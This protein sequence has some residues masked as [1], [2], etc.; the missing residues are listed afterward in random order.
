MRCM[1][2]EF[3]E[4]P[5]SGF[6]CTVSVCTVYQY[7][8][9]Q[10]PWS[11]TQKTRVFSTLYTMY[12]VHTVQQSQFFCIFCCLLS[13]RQESQFPNKFVYFFYFKES[14]AVIYISM[15]EF[16]VFHF[17]VYCSLPLQLLDPKALTIYYDRI[18][19]FTAK[20]NCYKHWNT[21][22]ISLCC[23]FVTLCYTIVNQYGA[24]TSAA[25]TFLQWKQISAG[26]KGKLIY[27]SNFP[28]L[29]K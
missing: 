17:L 11:A 10:I 9:M 16:N 13:G 28:L 14:L 24:A 21:S 27:Q 20:N 6:Y 19:G 4:D 2:I 26:S 22:T 5:G 25:Q 1:Y 23:S 18:T 12:C 15:S 3:T 8:M 7:Q 29:Q